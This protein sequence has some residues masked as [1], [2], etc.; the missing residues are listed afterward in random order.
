MRI[1]ELRA[2]PA[3][4]GAFD[5]GRYLCD[6]TFDPSDDPLTEADR[7][8]LSQMV[9]YLAFLWLRG[10]TELYESSLLPQSSSAYA[11]LD[12]Y[13]GHLDG[14]SELPRESGALPYRALVEFLMHYYPPP[15]RPPRRRLLRKLAAWW[16]GR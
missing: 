15:E 8:G 5:P 13:F 9:H 14:W 3:A 1:R 12:A 16:S 4:V 6:L 2:P 11:A 7:V 10:V